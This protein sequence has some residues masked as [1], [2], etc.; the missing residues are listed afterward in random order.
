VSSIAQFL[1]TTFAASFFQ[2][3]RLL[4]AKKLAQGSL[5][6]S[7]MLFLRFRENIPI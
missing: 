7:G 5:N 3:T 6:L 1:G 2:T 4:A